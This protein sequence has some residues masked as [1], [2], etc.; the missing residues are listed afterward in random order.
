MNTQ[1]IKYQTK[2]KR[3]SISEG[4]KPKGKLNVKETLVSLR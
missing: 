4:G 2:K 1:K 3:C